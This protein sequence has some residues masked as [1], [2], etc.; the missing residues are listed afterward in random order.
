M[1]DGPSLDSSGPQGFLKSV[2]Q[3]DRYQR[4]HAL[5]VAV[6]DICPNRGARVLD[7]GGYPGEL[8]SFL[9]EFTIVV[10]DLPSR[11]CC[12]RYVCASGLNLPF[13]DEM[14]DVV[15]CSDVLE[16]IARESRRQLILNLFRV[17]RG[18][19]C[20]GV[21]RGE[22]DVREAEH[23]L[24]MYFRFLHG[25]GHPWLA[26]HFTHGLPAP[27][28]VEDLLRSAKAR[29]A[30]RPNGYLNR[31]VVAMI[32]NRYLE[33]LDE[34]EQRL[35]RFNALYNKFFTA[36]DSRSPAYRDI[37]I[38]TIT[39]KPIPEILPC[40]EEDPGFDCLMR[41]F[42]ASGEEGD[43]FLRT[44]PMVS[45]VIVTYNH[46]ATLGPCIDA[47]RASRGLT[48]ELIVVDNSS[49][50]ASPAIAFE[51]SVT[52][53]RTGRNL[54]FAAAFNLGW[55]LSSGDI[56][57]SVNPDI[58]VDPWALDELV[59]ACLE[60]REAA[61]V[62][63]KLL[64]WDGN[65]LQHAGGAILPN[66][67]SVH[68]GRGQNPD[69]YHESAYVDYV[70]GALMAMKRHVLERLEG[71]D[72]RYWPAYYEETDYCFRVREHGL[73]VLYW[74]WA[75]ARHRENSA[76]G[77]ASESF[78]WAYH[79]SRLRFIGRHLKLRDI[80]AFVRAERG[81]RRGRDDADVELSGI[82]RA[83]KGWWWKLPMMLICRI[84]KK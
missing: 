56:V 27:S 70:T 5:S 1:N 49:N 41:S 45:V 74:P 43:L 83:W 31:W 58:L 40:R 3:F 78:F 82:R 80:A 33:T 8:G 10:A 11:T 73:R 23:A 39:A 9:P 50:D 48:P 22:D 42:L 35:S 55:R 25:T 64:D 62:G 7:V 76:L 30:V 61:V 69:Q 44:P 66:Y 53:V 84:G 46:E 36:A 20:L 12:P 14:F 15:V 38:A 47:L 68:V 51:S 28:E 2:I 21:P 32:I 13:L 67:C 81:F 16:H 54:G 6:R 57:V 52:F 19:V 63:A 72:E 24:D 17:S 75:M 71:L 4:L 65:A 34:A 60:H 77:A 37:Y 18:W 26:E 79:R 59:W 29:F